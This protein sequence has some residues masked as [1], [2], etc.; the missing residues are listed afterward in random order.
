M[1]QWVKDPA[2]SL[3]WPG[4][5]PWLG[6][7]HMPWAQPKEKANRQNQVLAYIFGFPEGEERE[8]GTQEILKAKKGHEFSK[9]DERHHFRFKEHNFNPKL[10]KTQ[11][12]KANFIQ[13]Y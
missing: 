12:R 8:N 11:L 9:I 10:H 13:H 3:L 1:A 6:N 4:F 2:L 5:I 7:F